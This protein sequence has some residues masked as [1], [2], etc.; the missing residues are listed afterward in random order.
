MKNT[1]IVQVLNRTTEKKKAPARWSLNKSIFVKY[2]TI[3]GISFIVFFMGTLLATIIKNNSYDNIFHITIS[4]NSILA[5]FLSLIF[6]SFAEF[7]WEDAYEKSLEIPKKI[8]T[9]FS[10]VIVIVL[11]LMNNIFD[12][13]SSVQKDNVLFT[14]QYEINLAFGITV[15]ILSIIHFVLLSLR[16]TY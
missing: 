7:L 1:T 13:L 16:K 11:F 15:V 2:I 8:V 3:W 6:S 12:I 5:L 9:A 10:F 4:N 14:I